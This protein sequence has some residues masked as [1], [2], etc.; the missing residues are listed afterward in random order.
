MV[1]SCLLFKYIMKT[2]S[3]LPT[4]LTHIRN[5]LHRSWKSYH[6][7][8]S[9]SLNGSGIQRSMTTPKNENYR[10]HSSCTIL[11]SCSFQKYM[12][13]MPIHYR[14]LLL[15]SVLFSILGLP[16][17]GEKI[18][19]QAAASCF[20][21][22]MLYFCVLYDNIEKKQSMKVHESMFSVLQRS[23]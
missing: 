8:V 6:V 22:N 4:C 18:L 16:L 21:L 15:H 14:L 2:K 10:G 13:L 7:K 12:L 19:P 23:N 9:L 5:L 1:F 11:N 3:F 20:Q 17:F